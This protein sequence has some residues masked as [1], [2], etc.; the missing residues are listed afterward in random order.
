[1]AFKTITIKPGEKVVIPPD[2]KIQSIITDGSISVTSNCPIPTPTSYK[3]GFFVYVVD[4]DDNTGHPMDESS[5]KLSK[6]YIGDNII[7]I[8]T[9][10]YGGVDLAGL[11]PTV[12]ELNS[13]IPDQSLMRFEHIKIAADFTKRKY[14]AL[15]F[16]APEDLFS[17]IKLSIDERNDGKAIFYLQPSESICGDYSY[18]W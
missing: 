11:H 13:R 1:M 10:G 3:C 15:F 12:A 14:I 18:S 5:I 9:F 8:N 7:D 6:L 2:V 16:R 4:D 17:G